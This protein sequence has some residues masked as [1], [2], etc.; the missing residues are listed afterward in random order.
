MSRH[1][2][3]GECCYIMK[4]MY[5]WRR[6]VSLVIATIIITVIFLAAVGTFNKK[7]K[8]TPGKVIQE[9]NTNVYI[10]LAVC[11]PVVIILVVMG[12][13]VYRQQQQLQQHVGIDFYS[14]HQPPMMMGYSQNQL[15][16]PQNQNTRFQQ[17][18][19]AFYNVYTGQMMTYPPNI[20][21]YGQRLNTY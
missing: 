3:R 14:M 8:N 13:V 5:G 6:Y 18:P 20:T 10:I 7:G 1:S 16:P 15:M 12:C 21:A 9:S 19:N 11:A 4:W 2:D 17:Q